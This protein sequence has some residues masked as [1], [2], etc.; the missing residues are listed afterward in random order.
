MTAIS[1]LVDCTLQLRIALILLSS[2]AI[3]YSAK[4]SHRDTLHD[5]LITSALNRPMTRSSL[6]EGE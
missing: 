2:S 6:H 1:K 5:W 4:E 3:A